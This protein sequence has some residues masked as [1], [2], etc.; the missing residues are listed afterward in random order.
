MAARAHRHVHGPHCRHRPVL[1]QAEAVGRIEAL[2]RDR[3]R[4]KPSVPIRVVE[5]ATTEI[6]FPPRETRI[7]FWTGNDAEHQYRIFKPAARVI[8]ADLP[9]WWMRDALILDEFPFCDC[10]G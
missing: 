7:T 9:P 6:G 4:L 1:A 5:M 2:A 3:F 8:L 10:C